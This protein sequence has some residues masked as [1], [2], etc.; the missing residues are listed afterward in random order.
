MTTVEAD[1]ILQTVLGMDYIRVEKSKSG[2]SVRFSAEIW[3]FVILA[4]SLTVLT[5]GTWKFLDRAREG[6][7]ELGLLSPF[8]KP[9]KI[10]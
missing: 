5:F 1:G 3:V 6:D 10:D 7:E 2:Q 9:V 8:S 4:I